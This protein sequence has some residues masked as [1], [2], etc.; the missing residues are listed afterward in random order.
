M[1]FIEIVNKIVEANQPKC[2]KDSGHAWEQICVE[3]AE[4][5]ISLSNNGL[6]SA[7][8]KLL[9]FHL[10][11]CWTMQDSYNF[12]G[13][14]SWLRDNR[15]TKKESLQIPNFVNCFSQFFDQNKMFADW[16]ASSTIRGYPYTIRIAE[17]YLWLKGS[18]KQAETINFFRH[19]LEA[20]NYNVDKPPQ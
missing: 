11:V 7:A 2:L 19:S 6:R 10:P 1:N 3:L 4:Q 15:L 12:S 17:K 18:G 16:A 14:H 9:W 20:L 13:L 5:K 8:S